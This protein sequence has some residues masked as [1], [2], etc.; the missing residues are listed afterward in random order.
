MSR[1]CSDP[2]F[3]S[4]SASS[5]PPVSEI[6]LSQ[7]RSLYRDKVRWPQQRLEVCRARLRQPRSSR[8]TRQA[9]FEACGRLTRRFSRLARQAHEAAASSKAKCFARPAWAT[10][11]PQVLH[12]AS[13]GEFGLQCSR[14]ECGRVWASVLH[15][16]SECGRLS[17]S[18]TFG[19]PQCLNSNVSFHGPAQR[20]WLSASRELKSHAV[21][22]TNPANPAEQD[23]LGR[24][25]LGSADTPAQPRADTPAL[26]LGCTLCPRQMKGG[27]APAN[28]GRGG[29]GRQTKGKSPSKPVKRRGGESPSNKRAGESPSNQGGEPSNTRGE[30][31]GEHVKRRGGESPSNEWRGEPVKRRGGSPSDCWTTF[32]AIHSDTIPNAGWPSAG[33]GTNGAR[34][35]GGMKDRGAACC[36]GKYQAG[37]RWDGE[38]QA[39]SLEG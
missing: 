33:L 18:R 4:M 9:A 22:R 37:E 34:E 5:V 2:F 35:K 12:A 23:L 31:R 26:R 27:G 10:P 17:A 29:A 39:R 13:V 24:C 32:Q 8:L 6:R 19:L 28:G 1:K 38:K 14:D 25:G 15:A 3:S 30:G 21:C 11:H 7:T 36:E 16:A 20:E